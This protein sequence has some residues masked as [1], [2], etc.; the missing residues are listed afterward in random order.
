MREVDFSML[1]DT[2]SH[3]SLRFALFFLFSFF[4]FLVFS[5]F[6]RAVLFGYGEKTRVMRGRPHLPRLRFGRISFYIILQ[7]F[8]RYIFLPYSIYL[9][10]IFS[11]LFAFG[12]LST[13]LGLGAFHRS[14]SNDYGRKTLFPRDFA[15][16][17]HCTE[18]FFT[19]L[20]RDDTSSRYSLGFPTSPQRKSYGLIAYERCKSFLA[21][22]HKISYRKVE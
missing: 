2:I 11:S 6:S 18:D 20:T 8:H 15:S 21:R 12:S 5:P 19:A 13:L 10:L 7:R 16:P 1:F 14:P 22:G 17:L 4:A 3:T 9:H